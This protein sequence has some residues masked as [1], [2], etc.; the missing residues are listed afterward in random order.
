MMP[1]LL[2]VILLLIPSLLHCPYSHGICKIYSFEMN[3]LFT[4]TSLIDC[5]SYLLST[6]MAVMAFKKLYQIYKI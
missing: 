4:M 1:L 5:I 3:N 2:S 6:C